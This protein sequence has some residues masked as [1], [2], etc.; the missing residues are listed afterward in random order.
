MKGILITLLIVT[1]LFCSSEESPKDYVP[2]K[3]TIYVTG[4]Y[5]VSCNEIVALY[6]GKRIRVIENGI[7][8]V[9]GYDKT[10]KQSFPYLGKRMM[11]DAIAGVKFHIFSSQQIKNSL[12]VGIMAPPIRSNGNSPW[13]I[14]FDLL[15]AGYAVTPKIGVVHG[16]DVL[17]QHNAKQ[18]KRGKWQ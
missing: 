11:N 18:Q 2:D 7:I 1:T 3:G 12:W 17:Y 15:K 9:S 14:R 10:A 8:C 5:A 4:L 13:K 6:N 16:L